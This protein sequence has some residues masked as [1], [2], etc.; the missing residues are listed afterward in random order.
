MKNKIIAIVLVLILIVSFSGCL[1][2][3]ATTEETDEKI[4]S[5]E[6]AADKTA[7][8][9]DDLEGLGGSLKD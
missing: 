2:P 7:E 3:P 6:E 4:K 5:K 1:G 8:V 9:G